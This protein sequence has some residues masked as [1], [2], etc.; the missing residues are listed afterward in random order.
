MQN[1]IIS[2]GLRNPYKK[3]TKRKSNYRKEVYRYMDVKMYKKYRK[4]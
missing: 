1:K 4:R 3:Y 2:K